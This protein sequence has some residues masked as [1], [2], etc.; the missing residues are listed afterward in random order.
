MKIITKKTN[1]DNV[2]QLEIT[3]MVLVHCSIVNNKQHL[4]SRVLPTLAPN[5]SF[6]K[7]HKQIIVVLSFFM[8]LNRFYQPKHHEPR[9]E[10]KNRMNFTLVFNHK[11]IYQ[12]IQLY[13]KIELTSVT[14]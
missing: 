12:D 9:K 4:D 10:K 7:F 2:A 14:N 5:K 3:E 13:I 1:T 8:H 6:E 11:G